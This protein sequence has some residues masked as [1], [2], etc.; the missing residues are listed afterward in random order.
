MPESRH[1]EWFAA[2]IMVAI[3]APVVAA[4]PAPDAQS[5]LAAQSQPQAFIEVNPDTIRPGE[6]IAI[7]ASCDD[8][9]H[10]D[11]DD[12][13]KITSAKAR[14]RAFGEVELTTRGGSRLLTGSAHIPSDTEPGTYAVNLRCPNALHATTDLKVVLPAKPTMGPATGGG[15]EAIGGP[16]TVLLSVAGGVVALALGAA[17]LVRGHSPRRGAGP[18]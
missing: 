7:V 16:P 10:D 4:A 13:D 6:T 2:S 12:D 9:K 17:L 14:S 18:A 1:L 5:G 15:G 3:V 8:K 11:D